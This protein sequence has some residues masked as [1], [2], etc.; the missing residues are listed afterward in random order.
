MHAHIADIAA[1]QGGAGSLTHRH[2]HMHRWA[3][4]AAHMPWDIPDQEVFPCLQ[5]PT[6]PPHLVCGSMPDTFRIVE[7]PSGSGATLFASAVRAL[8]Q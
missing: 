2:Y 8:L 3:K 4:S 5:T 1:W 7:G 6:H